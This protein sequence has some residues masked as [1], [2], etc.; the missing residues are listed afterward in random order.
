MIVDKFLFLP[1]KIRKK[2]IKRIA[3]PKKDL[4]RFT[5]ALQL[6]FVKKCVS[7]KQNHKERPKKRILILLL[8]KRP[9]TESF[10]ILFI[11]IA[12]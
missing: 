8:V 7:A 5:K 3:N 11:D 12:M 1:C 4:E 10:S 9:T 2:Q 6:G